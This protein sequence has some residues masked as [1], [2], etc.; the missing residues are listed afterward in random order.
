[1]TRA[2]LDTDC[3]ALCIVAPDTRQAA[4]CSYLQIFA[5]SY[6]LQP[7]QRP[8]DQ[9]RKHQGRCL[10]L[11]YPS[12]TFEKPTPRLDRRNE[13]TSPA[14][15]APPKSAKNTSPSPAERR[16][17]FHADQA[18]DL[19]DGIRAADPSPLHRQTDVEPCDIFASG[20]LPTG[21]LKDDAPRMHYFPRP[22][23]N[24]PPNDK[25][26]VNQNLLQDA[27]PHI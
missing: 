25:N 18:T 5:G 7:M 9:R 16:E 24:Y 22:R 20:L 3:A 10:P 4:H 13:G 19:V 26:P 8:D 14:P 15:I 12:R 21:D 17:I 2:K 27:P 11:T 6:Y 1:M 23:E